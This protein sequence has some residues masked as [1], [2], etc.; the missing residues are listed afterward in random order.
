MWL[1][2]NTHSF[3]GSGG[4][5]GGG[6]NPDEKKLPRKLPRRC[7]LGEVVVFATDGGPFGLSPDVLLLL[8]VGAGSV[9][10]RVVAL[11]E[12]ELAYSDDKRCARSE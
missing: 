9:V 11:L 6:G 7:E 3:S 1:G 10:I 4:A 2:E 5:G 12:L 8:K